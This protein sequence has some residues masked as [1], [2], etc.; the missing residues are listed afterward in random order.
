MA[1]DDAALLLTIITGVALCLD[2][3]SRRS[4]MTIARI[5]ALLTRVAET[6]ALAAVTRPCAIC[7]EM[8]RTYSLGQAAARRHEL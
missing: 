1:D 6:I 4:G 3:I 7:L 2:C 5:D 8:K